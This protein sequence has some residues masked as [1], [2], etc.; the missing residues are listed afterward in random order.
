MNEFLES[1]R[2]SVFYPTRIH[3][4]HRPRAQLGLKSSCGWRTEHPNVVSSPQAASSAESLSASTVSRNFAA[5]TGNNCVSPTGPNILGKP[6]ANSERPSG[7]ARVRWRGPPFAAALPRGCAA[8]V[9]LLVHV[10]RV[11][12]VAA[13][14]FTRAV[15]A[16]L[17]TRTE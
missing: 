17:P 10:W 2:V 6:I 7:P 3:L 8:H 12:A 16:Y 5:G 4:N 14:C 15:Q 13:S 9:L 11:E 1:M